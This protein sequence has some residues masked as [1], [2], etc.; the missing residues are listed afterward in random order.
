MAWLEI[1]GSCVAGAD[2]SSL[3]CGDDG[4]GAVAQVELREGAADMGLDG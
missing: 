4:L 3:V 2:E 1:A